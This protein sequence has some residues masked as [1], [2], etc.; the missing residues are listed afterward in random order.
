[1]RMLMGKIVILRTSKDNGHPAVIV[2]GCVNED[3]ELM[4][5]GK[6][7]HA[8]RGFG[9]SQWQFIEYLEIDGFGNPDYANYDEAG[10]G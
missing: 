5:N 4:M 9:V 7:F 3:A 8:G 10:K 6:T 2:R 1:M